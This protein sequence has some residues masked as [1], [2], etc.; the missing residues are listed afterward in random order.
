MNES[1]SISIEREKL[2]KIIDEAKNGCDSA[3]EELCRYLYVKI[4]GYVFYRIKH[5]EDAEDLTS[6]VVLKI[7][8]NL[9]NQ[10]GN[11][12]AWIYKIAGNAV[13]DYYRRKRSGFGISYE[14]LPQE[15]PSDDNHKEILQ[16]DRLKEAMANLTKEQADVITLRFIQE[17][18]IKEVAQIM[19]KSVG[20]IKVL[21][22]RA[23][24]SLRDYFKRKGY[25]IKD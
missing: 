5:R 24:K 20:A 15:L 3:V 4:Y 16:V 6:E 13:I 7:I 8:K 1:A 12:Y 11:F 25:E 23:L 21:Q 10:R 9:K 19:K 18:G 17:Y 2:K 22:F 14:D